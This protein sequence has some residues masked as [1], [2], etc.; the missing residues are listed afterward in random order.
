MPDIHR[1][2]LRNAVAI[3][4]KAGGEVD[5]KY[6][7]ENGE[8]QTLFQWG[9]PPGVTKLRQ[10]MDYMP[11]DAW[12]EP[13]RNTAIFVGDAAIAPFIH[14]DRLET[15]AVPD[16]TPAQVTQGDLMIRQ[17]A[18]SLKALKMADRKRNR[19]EAREK[20]RK[21]VRDAQVIEEAND[22]TPVEEPVDDQNQDAQ[23]TSQD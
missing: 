5:C 15:A 19:E 4:P 9:L 17:M 1:F 10:A 21:E 3:S 22:P 11:A 2:Q 6:A 14:P 16:F 7:D 23:Q 18:K 13:A 20:R 8:I 12:L